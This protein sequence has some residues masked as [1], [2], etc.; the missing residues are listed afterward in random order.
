MNAISQAFRFCE[1]FFLFCLEFL[2]HN[3]LFGPLMFL[4]YSKAGR[5]NFIWKTHKE[6]RQTH[7]FSL[8]AQAFIIC[9]AKIKKGEPI[10]P[11][12]DHSKHW[13]TNW[14]IKVRQRT[15]EISH[16]NPH[17]KA[18]KTRIKTHSE[19]L[20]KTQEQRLLGPYTGAEQGEALN[21]GHMEEKREVWHISV[22]N[23]KPWPCKDFWTFIP[24]KHRSSPGH[25]EVLNK[26]ETV[27]H[28]KNFCLWSLLLHIKMNYFYSL[29]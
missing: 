16:G 17:H 19:F 20:R 6:K 8:F 2:C 10:P 26:I 25:T 28:V 15:R 11:W 5:S 23:S 13:Q 4:H 12:G 22:Q 9:K 7:H 24:L 18:S 21:K 3:T 14:C 27:P 29:A 1:V